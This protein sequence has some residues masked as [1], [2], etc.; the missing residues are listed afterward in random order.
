MLKLAV[1]AICKNE[2]EH[3]E[4]WL[5]SVQE[6]DYICVLDTGST[7]GTYEFL[8]KQSNVILRR[9]IIEPFRFDVA[10]N[11]SLELVPE[12]VDI[13]LPLDIDQ[14]MTPEFANKLKASWRKSYKKMTIPQY[15]KTTHRCGSWMCHSRDARWKYPVYEQI[16]AQT[17]A[18]CMNTMVVH[19]F[20]V[21]KAS[22]DMYPELAE[23]GVQENPIDPYCYQTRYRIRQEQLKRNKG[24]N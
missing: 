21:N 10:R 5:K 8:Q 17:D 22:H 1:Y 9:E 7:D 13:C 2:T 3:I 23:L 20:T 12:D 4:S 18:Q 15:F 14:L 24:G 11:K 6:A 19:D 16:D